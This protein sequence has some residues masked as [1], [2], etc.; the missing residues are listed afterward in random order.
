[1]RIV[2]TIAAGATLLTLAGEADL[3]DVAELNDALGRVVGPLTVDV[4]DLT[5]CDSSI[6]GA[7]ALK[8]REGTPITVTGASGTV[9]RV[10]EMTGF[11]DWLR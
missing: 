9:R 3:S 11:E 4:A 5:F 6:I 2:I 7:L 1:M 10:L 8:W